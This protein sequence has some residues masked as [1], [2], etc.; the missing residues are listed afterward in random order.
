MVARPALPVALAAGAAVL[1]V[2][3]A[4][5]SPGRLAQ[6]ALQEHARSIPSSNAQRY[7]WEE[8][9]SATVLGARKRLHLMVLQA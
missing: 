3:L 4:V 9:S 8:A 5:L 7:S 2:L 1:C 6:A